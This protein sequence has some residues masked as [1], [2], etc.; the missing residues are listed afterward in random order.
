ML[1]LSMVP[2]NAE[3][4]AVIK[5]IRKTERRQSTC[6]HLRTTPLGACRYG[7]EMNKLRLQREQLDHATKELAQREGQQR[8]SR[9]ALEHLERFCRQVAIGLDAMTFEERQQLLRLVVERITVEDGRVR[10]ETIIPTDN[11][12]KLRTRRAE[13]VEG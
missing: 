12:D 3:D 2:V 5:S 10:I 11:D 1:T 7:N 6:T 4:R 13:P 9:E 8:D